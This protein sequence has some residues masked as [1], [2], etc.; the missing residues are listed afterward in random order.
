MHSQLASDQRGRTNEAQLHFALGKA[1][2]QRREH[3]AAFAHYA[4]GNAL[5]R[6]D[7]PFDIERFERRCER[8]R[9]FFDA[10]FF[11]GRADAGDPS[12]APIFI[13][14]LPRSGSTLV[15]QILASHSQRRRHRCATGVS[16]SPTNCP[17][18]SVTSA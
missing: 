5:R 18:T 14:G 12:R 10:A 9:A 3:A 2:E 1:L 17:I 13:V 16:A 15:E 4:Q 6:L 8:I 11:A 7:A